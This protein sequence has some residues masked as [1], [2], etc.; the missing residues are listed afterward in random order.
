MAVVV[1]MTIAT[2][3]AFAPGAVSAQDAPRQC[4]GSNATIV[5]TSGDDYLIGTDGPDVIAALQGNDIIF[6]L[7]GD[8]IICGGFGNDIIF[9]GEGFDS[10][11]GAQGDDVLF[12]VHGL[13][14][15]LRQDTRGAR[16]FGGQGDDQIY[17]SARWDR[18][19]GG[20]GADL[21]VSF[22][23]RDWIRSGPGSDSIDG[24]LG[25]DDIRTSSGN[26]QI[27]VTV[28]DLIRAGIGA[29][30]C[31]MQGAATQ[32]WSC[33]N[34]RPSTR[35]SNTDVREIYGPPIVPP[36]QGEPVVVVQ[37]YQTFTI[38]G[39]RVGVPTSLDELPERASVVEFSGL[40]IDN[41]RG[42]PE[43]CAGAI[44]TSLPVQCGGIIIDGLAFHPSWT[45][46]Y[47]GVRMGNH[48]AR[49]TWPPVDGR[50]TLIEERSNEISVLDDPGFAL[51]LFPLPAECEDIEN[52]VPIGELRAWGTANPDR[53]AGLVSGNGPRLFATGDLDEVRAEL[54][55]A[56]AQACVVASPV[57]M[58]ELMAQ[59]AA[60]EQAL[61]DNEVQW[62][63]TS[64]GPGNR[65]TNNTIRIAVELAAADL[66]TIRFLTSAIDN[67]SLLEISSRLTIIE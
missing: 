8:D 9:G 45:T 12:S 60:V 53:F 13:S 20:P 36:W 63:S 33:E 40:F 11:F 50:A 32:L 3:T 2:V 52:L 54:D 21:I 6:G 49:Y 22:E 25:I 56:D 57:N 61:S 46:H 44:L 55:T 48:T 14:E 23:G 24:G 10:L 59:R 28:N 29:D 27:D 7:D 18:I 37:E 5:G 66:E 67:P 34:Q 42:G 38:D 31:N 39:A 62:L 47:P 15:K 64:S 4:S 41:G 65:A 19:Q 51:E 26:D 43:A 30:T 1:T 17:G 58:T 16:M 35:F